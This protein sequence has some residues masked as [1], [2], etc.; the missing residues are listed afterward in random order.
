M[1]KRANKPIVGLD[2][3]PSAITAA[4]VSVNGS[5]SI[6]RAAFVPLEAGIVRDGEVT[7]VEG[8]AEALRLMY[9]ENKGLGKRVR[10]GV[11]N[12]KIVVRVLELPPIANRKELET[13]VRFQAQDQ[14]P[15][16]LD[17]AVLDYQALDVVDHGAGPRQRVLLV[18]AR[19]DMVERVLASARAA[20]LRPEGIDLAAFGMIR[21][22]HQPGPDEP[23]M[24]LSVGGL[25]NL[26][27]AVG[28]RCLFTRVVGGGSEALAVE[29][30]ERRALTLEH[31]RA[32]LEHVGLTAPVQAIS[33]DEEIVSDARSVLQDGVRRI[34]VEARNS[35]DFHAAQEAQAH[36]GRVVLTGSALAIPGF[37]EALGAE[38]GLPVESGSLDGAPAGIEP[39]RLSVAAGLAIAE[40][41]HA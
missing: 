1:A 38:L 25:T 40:G 31:S 27:V 28:T 10:I 6:D 20:G 17:S 16:P 32:W 9:R 2:I 7:D 12:A 39:G 34:A 14:I 37:A 30:A 11:A 24:Y 41:P 15:M 35:L 36:V 18:A 4:E 26:A 23:V 22:L 33:G 3:D 21:A 8:L 5:V 29:L 19:R 13:A